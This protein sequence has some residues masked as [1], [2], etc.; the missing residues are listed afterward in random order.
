MVGSLSAVLGFL[1]AAEDTPTHCFSL[2]FRVLRFYFPLLSGAYFK[3]A[4]LSLSL[5][6][7]QLIE[8]YILFFSFCSL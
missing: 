7:C 6:R 2:V 3:R 4:I 1:S 8:A 5:P